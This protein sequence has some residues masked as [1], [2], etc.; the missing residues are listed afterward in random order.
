[1]SD[2]PIMEHV[3]LLAKRLASRDRT[4]S[5]DASKALTAVGP[6]AIA[7]LLSILRR[8]RR[9]AFW[10]IVAIMS[11]VQMLVL[12][13]LDLLAGHERAGGP[14]HHAALAVAL[15][16]GW[17]FAVSRRHR[18]VVAFLGA[19]RDKRTLGPMLRG[20]PGGRGQLTWGDGRSLA[21][22]LVSL[23]STIDPSDSDLLSDAERQCLRLCLN[24]SDKRLAAAGLHAICA[25]G[26]AERDLIAVRKFA[27]GAYVS[28]RDP[29]LR[30]AAWRALPAISARIERRGQ[31]TTLLRP[32]HDP[33]NLADILVR[34]APAGAQPDTSLL[35]SPAQPDDPC[36]HEPVGE[37]EEPAVVARRT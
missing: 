3:D 35:V 25:I 19:T 9:I 21:P 7:P 17:R 32:A 22:A 27:K 26:D 28:R 11:A 4:V 29:E 13:L 14:H 5:A 2:E 18:A 8:D 36:L 16:V 33:T 10:R 24:S 31:Q 12:I 15:V 20:L 23:L 6:E 34:P 1:M 30:D 37:A